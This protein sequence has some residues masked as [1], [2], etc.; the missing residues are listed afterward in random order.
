[1]VRISP[2]PPSSGSAPHRHDDFG[3]RGIVALFLP[4]R[5]AGWAWLTIMALTGA[6][7]YS[8]ADLAAYRQRVFRAPRCFRAVSAES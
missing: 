7:S 5:L 2:S 4:E 1:M 6:V 8:A 3:V